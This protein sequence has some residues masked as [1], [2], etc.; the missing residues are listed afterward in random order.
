LRT[1]LCDGSAWRKF[2]EIVAAQG[3]DASKLEKLSQVH[4]A[5]VIREVRADRS[6][7]LTRVDAYQTGLAVLNLGAGRS[8]ASDPVDFAVGVDQLAKTGTQQQPGDLLARIHA[9]S[10][11]A[12]AAAEHTLR[13]GITL[14]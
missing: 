4:R 2:Q 1:F 6:G 3:G 5:P 13:E 8:K 11:A 7:M 10:E 12:A 9:R 14:E